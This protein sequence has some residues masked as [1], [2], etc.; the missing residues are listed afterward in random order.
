MRRLRHFCRK[1]PTTGNRDDTETVGAGTGALHVDREP[2][3][4]RRR[5][6]VH[7]RTRPESVELRVHP[8]TEQIRVVHAH[9][10]VEPRGGPWIEPIEREHPAESHVD[11]PRGPASVSVRI[12]ALNRRLRNTRAVRGRPQAEPETNLS[13]GHDRK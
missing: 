10:F 4:P 5:S 11:S 6:D 13:I 12:G 2:Y 3:D 7:L 8:F 9:L 1:S